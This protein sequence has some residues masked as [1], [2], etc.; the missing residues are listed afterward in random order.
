MFV[1][2]SMLWRIWKG[3]AKALFVGGEI[4]NLKVTPP[5]NVRKI[6][7]NERGRR[8]VITVTEW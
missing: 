5:Q 2:S 3:F 7:V 4:A 1:V 8:T 6:T